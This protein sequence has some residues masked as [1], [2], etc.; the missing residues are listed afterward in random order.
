LKTFGIFAQESGPLVDAVAAGLGALGHQGAFQL[1]GVWRPLLART[2]LAGAVVLGT[3]GVYDEIAASYLAAKKPVAVVRSPYLPEAHRVFVGSGAIDWLPDDLGA[4]ER[5]EALDLELAERRRV[6]AQ[7]IVVLGRAAGSGSTASAVAIWAQET[8]AKLRA[9]SDSRIT[10]RPDPGEVVP[11]SGYDET[12]WP[13]DE[14]LAEVLSR[15]WLVVTNGAE[16]GLWA[17]IAGLPVISDAVAVYSSLTDSLPKLATIRP[18]ALSKVRVLLRRI[19]AAQVTHDELAKGSALAAALDGKRLSE[20]ELEA[21]EAV[22]EPPPL[23]VAEPE[24][25]AGEELP[26]ATK[27]ESAG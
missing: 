10:W 14:P 25:S 24:T 20:K 11:A 6:K 22:A 27:T 9:M 17:I 21:L 16:S 26:V 19:L 1:A 15:A 3:D 12:S 5:L 7:S 18:P 8:V 2:D 4:P 13:G 23:P